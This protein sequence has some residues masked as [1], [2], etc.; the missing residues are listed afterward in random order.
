MELIL[1]ITLSIGMGLVPMMVYAIMFTWADRYEKE[2][3]WLMAAVFLW[4]AVAAA[5][6]AY[7]LNTLFG[8][9]VFAL[10]GSEAAADLGSAVLSAPLVEEVVK[11]LAVVAVYL[12]FRSEFSS[13]LDGVLYGALVGFGFA[14][15][16]NVNYIFSG[17]SDGGLAGLAGMTILRAF[18]L[19]F[20][21]AALTSCTGMGMAWLRLGRGPVRFL[22]PLAG[23]G[24]AIGLHAMHNLLASLG[25]LFCL[26]GLALDWM[27]YLGMFA[28]IA[29][30]VWR[31]GQVMRAQLRE[32][33]A[34]GLISAQQYA[35]ACSLT[36][37]LAAR[38]GALAA[39]TWWNSGRFYDLLGELAFRKHLLARR[40]A[41]HEP[42][43]PGDIARLR[44]QIA[45][46]ARSAA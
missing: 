18:G 40:G 27:G 26:L 36:G 15:T 38:W 11:G 21:H 42:E 20:L 37:Q 19:A 5:G 14:A 7:V 31:E 2:P 8:I 45:A 23:L 16:E 35:A 29:V 44:G 1:G 43:A 22:A 34:L 33:V 41:G 25:S 17:F 24:A 30:L 32:E 6:T 13:L 12:F 10:T 28:T 9:S 4:G 3:V 46:L 39:G